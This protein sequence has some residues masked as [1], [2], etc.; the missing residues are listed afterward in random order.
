[1]FGFPIDTSTL[2]TPLHYGD[3]HFHNDVLQHSL[4]SGYSTDPE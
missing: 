2:G 3:F 1:M 4:T